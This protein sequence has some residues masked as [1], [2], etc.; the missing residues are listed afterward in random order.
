ML[1]WSSG[2]TV[3][4]HSKKEG[5]EDISEV[6]Y[7]DLQRSMGG[8]GVFKALFFFLVLGI[9]IKKNGGFAKKQRQEI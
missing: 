8:G 9:S 7:I 3:S 1:D 4:K 2:R 5:T 6:T